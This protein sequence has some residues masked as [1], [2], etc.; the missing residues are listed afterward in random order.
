K[1]I[2]NQIYKKNEQLALVEKKIM[3]LEKDKNGKETIIDEVK[4]GL[5]E[6]DIGIY[7]I[8]TDSY[9]KEVENFTALYKN[10]NKDSILEE[11]KFIEEK[12]RERQIGRRE[13]EGKLN[14]IKSNKKRDEELL[15]R[16][17][18]SA[19]YPV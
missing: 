6:I 11:R 15:K 12:L 5:K 16:K 10:L 13:I 4:E 3:L 2:N 7:D 9:Y 18:A 14:E 8:L 1:R 17:Y 19:N